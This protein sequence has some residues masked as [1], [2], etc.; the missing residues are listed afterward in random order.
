MASFER[1]V[2]GDVAELAEY[3]AKLHEL[4]NLIDQG[5]ATAG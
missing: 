2:P 5:S 1:T 4:F 3:L